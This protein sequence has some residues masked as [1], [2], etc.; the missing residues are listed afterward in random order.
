MQQACWHRW[1]VKGESSKPE[2]S[3]ISTGVRTW[4][5]TPSRIQDAAISLCAIG[6]S[7]ISQN[8]TAVTLHERSTHPHQTTQSFT[9]YP[10]LTSNARHWAACKAY[11]FWDAFL[12]APGRPAASAFFTSFS[13]AAASSSGLINPALWRALPAKHMSTLCPFLL[14]WISQLARSVRSSIHAFS[15]SLHHMWIPSCSHWWLGHWFSDSFISSV[16][17]SL[18]HPFSMYLSTQSSVSISLS[19]ILH[20]I[21]RS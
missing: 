16:T 12:R 8:K 18:I 14:H 5:N 1:V 11:L 7:H 13:W 6:Q 15:I 9:G 3:C 4:S 21:P 19:N 17:L 20:D 2:K 10:D